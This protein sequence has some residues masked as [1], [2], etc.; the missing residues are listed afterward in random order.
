MKRFGFLESAFG[1]SGRSG[2]AGSAGQ[3]NTPNPVVS[4]EKRADGLEV[5]QKDGVLRLEVKR[6]ICCM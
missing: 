2:S 4:F 5:R 6:T 3:W 1:W